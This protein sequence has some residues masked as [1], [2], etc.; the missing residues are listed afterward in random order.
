MDGNCETEG[1]EYEDWNIVSFIFIALN[2]SLLYREKRGYKFN[3]NKKIGSWKEYFSSVT[4]VWWKK[5]RRV[6]IEKWNVS[7]N[8]ISTFK[9]GLHSIRLG[10]ERNFGF[11]DVE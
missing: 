6:G 11:L 2:V 4:K 7:N 1:I 5:T 10:G 3:S 9:K 8:A